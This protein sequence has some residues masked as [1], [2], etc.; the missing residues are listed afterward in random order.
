MK[1]I[2][3]IIADD[4]ATRGLTL[5]D[6]KFLQ[7][8]R[9]ST[10]LI[11]FALFVFINIFCD[12]FL[13]AYIF[14]TQLDSQVNIMFEVLKWGLVVLLIIIGNYLVSSLQKGEGF[15]R[16]T[17]IGVMVAFAPILLFKLPLSII[18]NFLTYNEG[19]IVELY[20]TFTMAWTLFLLI[21]AI[22]EVHNYSFKKT[23][24][25]STLNAYEPN[26]LIRIAPNSLSF[27][28]IG[29]LVPHFSANC[30]VLMK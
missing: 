17:F 6:I 3:K 20:T 25:F 23:L 21:Y 15:F 1:K 28:A 13:T 2:T 24:G 11:F 10:G 8:I 4:L 7:K 18:S 12:T 27:I 19:F 9:F 14:R 22:K 30:F 26:P 5:Y 16:D 29:L